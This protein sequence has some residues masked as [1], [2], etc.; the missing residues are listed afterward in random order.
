MSRIDEKT[1]KKIISLYMK[2]NN[3]TKIAKIVGFTR[4][5]VTRV[6]N[7]YRVQVKQVGEIERDKVSSEVSKACL[8]SI[9]KVSSLKDEVIKKLRDIIEKENLPIVQTTKTIIRSYENCPE[10]DYKEVQITEMPSERLLAL[11]LMAGANVMRI[12]GVVDKNEN[13]TNYSDLDDSLRR[14]QAID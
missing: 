5:P 14:M 1:A 8:Q 10:K 11:Q 6:V 3:I 4:G 2:G 13:K 9:D 7:E 12:L